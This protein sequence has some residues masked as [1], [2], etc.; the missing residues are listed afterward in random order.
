MARPRETAKTKLI[1]LVFLVV[2]VLTLVSCILLNQPRDDHS[3][4]SCR[5]FRTR[6]THGRRTQLLGMG[7]G[8]VGW[9]QSVDPAAQ[10]ANTTS[11][12]SNATLL[13][14]EAI[15]APYSKMSV[16]AVVTMLASVAQL[17]KN[18]AEAV[19]SLHLLLAGHSVVLVDKAS[20]FGGN[21]AKASS[22][23]NGC[24]TDQQKE[25][26]IDD[27]PQRF[28][29]DTLKSS[30]RDKD[31]YTGR[32]ARKMAD[33]S[34]EAVAWLAEHAGV[35]LPDVGRMGGHSADRT[36]RPRG[37][38]SGA[39]FVSGLER[40]IGKYKGPATLTVHKATKLQELTR[41]GSNAGWHLRLRRVAVLPPIL[42]GVP[43][44]DGRVAEFAAKP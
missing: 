21:S 43:I 13:G 19:V 20:F 2:N 4:R 30:Q 15:A 37:R 1:R 12:S 7:L 33:M 36:H 9:T 31:S 41:I 3:S 28:F 14:A 42:E 16:A 8:Y 38:L 25:G 18:H 44:P 22:G 29:D 11:D 17:H 23:I 32:L 26:K 27:S 10:P 34:A 5:V 24:L 40:A 35:E 6:L 39:A